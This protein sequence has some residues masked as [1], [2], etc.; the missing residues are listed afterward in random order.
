VKAQRPAS[1][2]LKPPPLTVIVVPTGAAFGDNVMNGPTTVRLAEPASPVL[3][4]TVT[5]YVPGETVPMKKLP[6]GAPLPGVT[7]VQVGVLMS[8]AGPL[9]VH[10][11]SAA[12]NPAPLI[13]IAAPT[14]PELGTR[15]IVGWDMT[16]KVAEALSPP[17][18]AVRVMV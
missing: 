3:P 6:V 17:G 10:V 18:A 14:G 5:V 9:I 13:T 16:V 11:V 2:V 12:E 4:V 15:V 7:K 1:A 8:N